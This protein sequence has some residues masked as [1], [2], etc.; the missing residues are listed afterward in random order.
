MPHHYLEVFATCDDLIAT[1]SDTLG[2]NILGNVNAC[3]TV[4]P[5]VPTFNSQPYLPRYY[6]IAP[7]NQGPANITLYFTQDDFDDYNLAAGAFPQ[8]PAVQATGTA[9]F[10]ISQ[11]PGGFLPGAS[12]ATTIVHTVTATWNIALNRWEV[13]LPVASFSGFYCHACNPL[14]SALPAAITNFKGT[15]TETTDLLTWSTTSE[16]NNAH[17]NVLY[18]NDG[19]NFSRLTSVNSKATSGNSNVVLNYSAENNMPKLGHNYYKLEQV[20]IDGKSLISSQVVDLMW[21][22][23]GSTISVYPNPTSNELNIDIYTTKAENS[24]IKILDMSGRILKEIQTKLFVGAN[25]IQTNIGELATGIYTV[26]ILEN[27]KIT[28]VSKVEKQ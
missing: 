2:G 24:T 21:G 13:T 17:F 14:N 28:Q 6:D 3:V 27:N 16:L 8:I 12:G 15:K 18:S 1:V 20:D 22:V 7:T 4:L 5:T 11:V 19:K 10:C 25:S 26:Q 23:N 9:T